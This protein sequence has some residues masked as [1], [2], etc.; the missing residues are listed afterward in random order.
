MFI[1]IASGDTSRERGNPRTCT[2]WWQ[3]QQQKQQILIKTVLHGFKMAFPWRF[4]NC[5]LILP[6][7]YLILNK[8]ISLST[9]PK[10]FFSPSA[11]F[12]I[13]NI[14]NI[15]VTM[16]SWWHNGYHEN[17]AEI[18][19]SEPL[20]SAVCWVLYLIKMAKLLPPSMANSILLHL[21]FKA[22]ESKAALHCCIPP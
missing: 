19:S 18:V 1:K 16:V 9:F 15:I 8:H 14:R 3:G 10:V 22:S 17:K 6:Y 11:F 20:L 5:W 4:N 2:I 13:W 7:D 21:G 12:N